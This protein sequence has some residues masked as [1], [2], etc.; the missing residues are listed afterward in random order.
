MTKTVRLSAGG[1]STQL[2]SLHGVCTSLGRYCMGVTLSDRGDIRG[3]DELI[4]GVIEAQR[5]WGGWVDIC[6]ILACETTY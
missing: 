4:E 2:E 5:E 1:L 6:S 3:A